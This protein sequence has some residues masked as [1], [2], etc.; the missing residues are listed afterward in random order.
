MAMFCL[1]SYKYVVANATLSVF[2]SD[3]ALATTYLGFVVTLREI[4][5]TTKIIETLQ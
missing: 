4:E 3:V 2:N 1:S 5:E